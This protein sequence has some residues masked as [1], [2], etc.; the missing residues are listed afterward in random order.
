MPMLKHR[1]IRRKCW[2]CGWR[3]ARPWPGNFSSSRCSGW[4]AK[5][6]ALRKYAER[7]PPFCSIWHPS[8]SYSSRFQLHPSPS[9]YWG[10]ATCG[11]LRLFCFLF[12]LQRLTCLIHFGLCWL[13][14]WVPPFISCAF[15]VWGYLWRGYSF[16]GALSL[17][18][19]IQK[20]F[21]SFLSVIR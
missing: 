16:F 6:A 8:P 14:A 13:L 2:R 15:R 20:S 4:R 18:E 3:S 12:W 10:Y 17:F 1:K 5:E 9:P 21:G 19:P 11:R 7:H